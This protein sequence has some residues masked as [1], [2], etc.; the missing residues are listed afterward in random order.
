MSSLTII[1]V[2][3]AVIRKGDQYLACQRSETMREPLR[4]E[5]P[6]GKIEMGESLFAALHREMH[7]E[8]ATKISIR[9]ILR[10]SSFEQNHKV[11]Q[12]N[13]LLCV[14]V[15]DAFELKEHKASRWLTAQEFPELD[16][17]DADLEV[18]DLLQIKT[19]EDTRW[20]SI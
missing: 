14:M 13:A 7:E 2:V 18:L 16:W 4:W 3:C 8:L 11:I 1:P 20:W 15:S 5:F 19:L 9:G 6:G 12:L 10:A 17:C